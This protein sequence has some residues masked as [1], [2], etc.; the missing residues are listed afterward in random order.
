MRK[1]KGRFAIGTAFKCPKLIYKSPSF[2]VLIP[3]N[4]L[5]F[6]LEY[7]QREFQLFLLQYL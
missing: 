1:T 2:Y 7:L 4:F 5:P 6:S 3:I